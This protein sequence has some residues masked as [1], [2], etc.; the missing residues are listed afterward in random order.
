MNTAVIFIINNSFCCSGAT[1]FSL[2]TCIDELIK[3][4]GNV[5]QL[6]MTNREASVQKQQLVQCP[7]NFDNVCIETNQELSI[8]ISIKL[9]S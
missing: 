1:V 2:H 4:R 3:L 5:V 9:L 8:D 7:V 6:D